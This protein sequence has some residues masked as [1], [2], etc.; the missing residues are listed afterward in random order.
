MELPTPA[1][2]MTPKKTAIISEVRR[3]KGSVNKP[4]SASKSLFLRMKLVAVPATVA[5]ADIIIR[6]RSS[7]RCST[8][9]LGS[10]STV[11][12][13]SVPEKR[14]PYTPTLLSHAA[15]ENA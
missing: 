3:R 14:P 1:R 2:E 12:F 9:D 5:K 11:V 13:P 4:R 6:L 7:A 8:K 10:S 15:T